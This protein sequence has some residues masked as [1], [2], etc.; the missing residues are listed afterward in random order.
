MNID[1]NEKDREIYENELKDFL[2]SKIFDAHVHVFDESNFTDDYKVPPK[3]P[4]HKFGDGKCFK[5][6][7][8]MAYTKKMLPDQEIYFTHFGGPDKDANREKAAEYTGKNSD[9]I[10]SFGMILTSPK[11][12][13]DDIVNRIENNKLVG[14]KP[15]LTFVDWKKPND[16]T[17][18]DMFTKDQLEYAN[19]KELKITL[20]IPRSARLADPLNQKQM[21]ELCRKYPKI[22]IIF[23]HIGRAYFLQNIT[24]F[25]SELATCKN[26]WLDTAMVNHEGV[27][28]YT[29][30]NF[31]R[32]RIL[33][34][35]DAP[36][37]YLRG[38]SVE[39]NNQYAYLMAEDY[40][41]GS[42]IY[43]SEHTV[44]FT[45]FFYEQLRGIKLAAQRAKL[46][47]TEIENILFSNAYQLFSRSF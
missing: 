30:N 34:A 17:I 32:E 42:S 1:Y 13:I 39:I 20:H 26:A 46:S 23:A 21:I 47:D 12:K 31:P 18:E 45:S 36:I 27:L 19:E 29:F 5:I 33:F 8:Y 4:Y 16:V 14:Y 3:S 25:L 35:S 40:E 7:T 11:D 44:E 22:Q 9:N 15:Y 41:I 10:K 2:P 37:A 43:D 38:K 24:G 28:E 6:D